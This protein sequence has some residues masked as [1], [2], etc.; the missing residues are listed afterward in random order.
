MATC[1]NDAGGGVVLDIDL[2][3]EKRWH[4]RDGLVSPNGVLER[5]EMWNA[6]FYPN[7]KLLIVAYGL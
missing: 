1:H 5:R 3:G 4:D 7:Y 2:R 6:I